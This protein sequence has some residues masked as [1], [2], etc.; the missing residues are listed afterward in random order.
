MTAQDQDR[1]A[2]IDALVESLPVDELC[3]LASG[4]DMWTSFAEP[5]IGLGK[6]AFS[7]GPVGVRGLK[8]DVHNTSACT[9]SPT[10]L[11]ATWDVDLVQQV[12]ALCASEARRQGVDVVLAPT[13]NLHRTPFGGRHFECYSEDPVLSGRIGA[14]WVRGLQRHGVGACVKHFICNDQ[15][16]DRTTIDVHVDDRTLN[17]LYLAPFDEIEHAARPWSYMSAYNS[18]NGDQMSWSPLL[19]EVLR[20]R[21]DSDAAVVTDWGANRETVPSGREGVDLCMCGPETPWSDGRLADAVRAGE[22]P[23]EAVRAKVAHLLELA[24]KAGKLDGFEPA[25]HTPAPVVDDQEVSRLLRRV[26]AASMVLVRNDGVLPLTVTEPTR[27]AVLGPNALR[28]RHT[29]G[30]SASVFPREVKQP[31]ASLRKAL[32]GWELAFAEGVRFGDRT[33]S[34]WG[35]EVRLPDESGDGILA[36][37]FD[38]SGA[39]LTREVRLS[40]SFNWVEGFGEVASESVAELV[41][42]TRYTAPVDGS[43]LVGASGIGEFTVLLDGQL[44]VEGLLQPH[45]D[46]PLAESLAVPPQLLR[47]V[48]LAE[49]QTVELEL[50]FR[51]RL[52]LTRHNPVFTCS[53]NLGRPWEGDD[54]ELQRAVDLAAASDLAILVV[55]TNE[56]VE[57]EGFDRNCLSLPGRQDELVSRVAAANPRTVVVVNSGAPVLM[58][59]LDE[60]SAV[61]LAWFG[62][63]E[64]GDALADVLIGAAEPAGRAPTSWPT[65]EQVV[66][67]PHLPVDGVLDYAEGIHIGHREYARRGWRAAVPFGAGLGYTSWTL[68]HV[69]LEGR[70]VTARVS[71][72]G[73]RPGAQVVQVY[74]SRRESAVDRPAL[75]LATFA[76]VE[77]D[78]GQ[79]VEVTLELPRRAVE[80]WQGTTA[81]GGFVVEPGD[82]EVLVGFDAEHLESR[83]LTISAAA[84]FAK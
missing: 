55:G 19:D 30:G 58:P 62:G 41:W 72:T 21:W 61:L 49:G 29:G 47:P 70:R 7:D 24:A 6:L 5:R 65:P 53:L 77:A 23:L 75:W 14:A 69:A 37:T 13:V 64:M 57:S 12:G 15:E 4:E 18:V 43:F 80:H 82:F 36:R 11:A 71:N 27:V 9:P 25:P 52:D 67:P 54:A 63:Q 28:G 59:W 78:A 44:L 50:R 35:D 81:E 10:A 68:D 46:R 32:P 83:A 42:Q 2:R 66:A 39:E 73:S 38:A 8:W 45:D 40:G 56:E 22:V 60:V 1:R 20:R 48:Q 16:T 3:R 76:R 33:P 79:T 34:V 26:A 84:H 17:E 74:L 31:F 51:P